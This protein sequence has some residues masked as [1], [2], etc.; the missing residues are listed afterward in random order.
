VFSLVARSTLGVQ[1]HGCGL[2]PHGRA[3]LRRVSPLRA[4]IPDAGVQVVYDANWR[5]K[6][7]TLLAR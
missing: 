6:Q 2:S 3:S 4:S 1:P 7:D 5:T